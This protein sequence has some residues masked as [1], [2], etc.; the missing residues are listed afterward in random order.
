MGTERHRADRTD[1][2]RPGAEGPVRSGGLLTSA[3]VNL[4]QI[5]Y[6]RGRPE[7][8][9]AMQAA[10]LGAAERIDDVYLQTEIMQLL[11]GAYSQ[12]GK[13][14]EARAQFERAVELRRQIY[15][16]R[17]HRVAAVLSSLG[18]AYA[19]KGEL[20]L[21]IAA[22]R[23]AVEIAEA[24]LGPVT[25]PTRLLL[26]PRLAMMCSDTGSPSSDAAAQKG[27]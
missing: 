18:N 27:S 24:A 8:V 14:A 15:G 20:D 6:Q 3:W 7:P 9:V 5:E 16:D 13:L 11:G 22:H 25:S 21:G 17:D 10:A 23:E 2:A 26:R 12:L 19:M 1:D 4:V